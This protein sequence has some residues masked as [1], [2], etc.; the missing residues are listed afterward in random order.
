MG[1]EAGSLFESPSLAFMIMI[2]IAGMCGEPKLTLKACSLVVKGLALA[3]IPFRALEHT[4]NLLLPSNLPVRA[5]QSLGGESMITQVDKSH[6]AQ[7]RQ[8]LVSM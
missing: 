7:S 1:L 6:R 8:L 4:R 2:L 5:V 3:C